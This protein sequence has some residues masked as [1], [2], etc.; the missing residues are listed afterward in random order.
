MQKNNIYKGSQKEGG[1]KV[2]P[3]A[4]VATKKQVGNE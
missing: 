2:E 3:L 4:M 1:G